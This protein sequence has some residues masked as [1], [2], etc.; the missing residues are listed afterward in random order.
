MKKRIFIILVTVIMTIGAVFGCAQKYPEL[1]VQETPDA[2]YAVTSNGGMVVQKGDFIYFVNGYKPIE[3]TDGKN[4]VWGKVEKGGIYYA[5]LV[6]GKEKEVVDYYGKYLTYDNSDNNFDEEFSGFYTEAKTYTDENDKE[7][8]RQQIAVYPVV[9]KLVTNGGYAEGGIFIIDD[10]IYYA[11][12]TTKRDKKGNVQ[13]ELVDFFRTRL[14]GT[15]TQYLYTSKSSE[16][17]PVYGYYK[18]NNDVYAVFYE[19]SEQKIYSVKIK[20]NK[21][22]QKPQVLADEVTGAVLPQKDVYFDGISQDMPEDYIY[23]TREIDIEKDENLTEGNVLERVRPDGSERKSVVTGANII[24]DKVSNGRLF[25]FIDGYQYT[26]NR[27]YFAVDL[28]DFDQRQPVEIFYELSDSFPES[29]F[30]VVYGPNDLLALA[31]KNSSVVLYIAGQEAGKTV[32]KENKAKIL[33]VDNNDAYFAVNDSGGDDFS[34]V[35][36][37]K[38]NYFN[39]RYEKLPQNTIKL[40]F[41][42]IDI[43]GGYL[44]Y[45]ST[46]NEIAQTIKS[47]DKEVTILAK[48]D[49]YIRLQNLNSA[50]KTEWDMGWLDKEDYPEEYKK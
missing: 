33:Y 44:F 37:Y 18:Y 50:S 21:T 35:N 8:T 48:T 28:T 11:S 31:L 2:K 42:N 15:G 1:D 10:Y 12:P 36:L 13:Y 49:Y 46:I 39:E 40:D 34:L 14:D 4:N 17:K 16:Q 20:D 27:Y 7:Q 47:G 25:Y 5:K 9:S 45:V 19:P 32:Y 30:G 6:G 29:V 38:I 26:A 22:V 24:L 43:A 23:Y 3:D 41:L